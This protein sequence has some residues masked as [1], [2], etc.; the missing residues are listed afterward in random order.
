MSHQVYKAVKPKLFAVAMI[1]KLS[2]PLSRNLRCDDS[3]VFIPAFPLRASRGHRP[4]RRTQ[5]QQQ[6]RNNSAGSTPRRG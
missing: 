4:Y 3:F 5:G 6:S 2:Q 1:S